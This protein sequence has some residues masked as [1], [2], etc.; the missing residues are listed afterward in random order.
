MTAT[1]D[2]QKP[3]R[4]ILTKD[5]KTIRVL[6]VDQ[7]RVIIGRSP[8]NDL[9]VESSFVSRHHAMLIRNGNATFLMDLNSTNGTTVNSRRISNQ[10]LMHNDIISLGSHRI[11][12][13]H[14]AATEMMMH[15]AAGMAETIVMKSLQVVEREFRQ[16]PP[17]QLFDPYVKLE[18]RLGGYR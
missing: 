12:F 3:P 13:I 14:E 7:P 2:R 8:H 18:V 16:R 1:D 6:T 5:G 4:L 10:V 9:Q 17:I 15:E 11:K